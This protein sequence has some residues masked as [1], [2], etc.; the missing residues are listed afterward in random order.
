[1]SGLWVSQIAGVLRLE[2]KKTAFSKRGW[3]IYCLAAAPVFISLLHWLV[4]SRSLSRNHSVGED[5]I[6]F[7]ALFLFFCLRGSMFFGWMGRPRLIYTD[8]SIA[9]HFTSISWAL[10]QLTRNT[11]SVS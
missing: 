4:E 2:L 5:S 6:I 7:A 9:V 11:A 10:T 3:W 8:F 1:M